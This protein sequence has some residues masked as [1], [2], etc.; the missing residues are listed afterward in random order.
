MTDLD[1]AAHLSEVLAA[2]LEGVQ[3]VDP[4]SPKLKEAWALALEIGSALGD[5][6]GRFHNWSA[7]PA[8]AEFRSY[9]SGNP[10]AR[11]GLLFHFG[12]MMGSAERLGLKRRW[13]DEMVASERVEASADDA[14]LVVGDCWL[15]A[16]TSHPGLLRHF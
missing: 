9:F 1:P 13:M 5:F 12:C 4:D 16:C 11:E 3:T 7:L 6:L 2:S 10:G 8:Q 15:G 14:V